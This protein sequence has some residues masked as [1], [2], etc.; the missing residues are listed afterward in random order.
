MEL[1]VFLSGIALAGSA[2]LWLFFRARAE[3]SRLRDDLDHVEEEKEIV[4]DFMRKLSEDI[5]DGPDND[6]L[7]KRIVRVT[8]LSCGALSACIYER[9]KSGSLKVRAVEGLFPPQRFIAGR[10]LEDASSRTEFLEEVLTNQELEPN[11]GLIGSV[12]NH[13]KGLLIKDAQKD[14]RVIRHQD[15]ALK[16]TSMM[17]VPMIYGDDL[18]GVL[19]MVNPIN[20]RFF[21]ETD[22]SVAS[23][24]ASYASLALKNSETFNAVVERNK[25]DFDLRLASSVQSYLLPSHLPHVDGLSSDFRYKPHQK[26]GGDFFDFFELPDGSYGLVIADVSGKGVSAAIITAICQTKFSYIAKTGKSPAETLKVLNAE[27]AGFIR[28]DMF[29]TITYA[30]LEPSLSKITFARAGHEKPVHYVYAE[31]QAV[32]L[33]SSGTAVGMV[34]PEIFDAVIEEKTIELGRGDIFLLYTDG[35]TEAVNTDGKEFSSKR[36]IEVVELL[37]NQSPREI[38]DGIMRSLEKFAMVKASYADDLTLLTVKR[39]I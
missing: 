20:G 31:K 19:A 11:E 39:D 2:G 28:Q 4:L 3:L 14:P 15:E 18:R 12:A 22:F 8:A 29:I 38:D 5:G 32:A 33:K 13:R 34:D 26:I 7:Y 36:L 37:H 25:L 10:K 16:I 21:S 17:V 6:K 9:T 23:T 27:I 1:I 24:L 30:I 35:L